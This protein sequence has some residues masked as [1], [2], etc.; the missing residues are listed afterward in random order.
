MAAETIH[1]RPSAG[2]W[3]RLA[4]LREALGRELDR[5]AEEVSV[6]DA[7][8]QALAGEHARRCRPE[9]KSR[10]SL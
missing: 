9:K 4:E 5:P 1:F 10:K 6:T 3:K 7:V 2:D 8:R